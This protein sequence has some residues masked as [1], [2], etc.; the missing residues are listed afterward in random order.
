M[1]RPAA[2]SA[3]ALRPTSMLLGFAL[4]LLISGA[5]GP[6][7]ASDLVWTQEDWSGGQ[8]ESAVGIDPEIDPG[9]LV[10]ENHIDDF[11]V[12][13][14]PSEHQGLWSMEAY[15]D[16][17]FIT[18]GAYPYGL[19]GADVVVYDYLTNNFE[20]VYSPR[21]YGLHLVK[22]FDDVLYLPGPEA[23]D[24]T[25]QA[26]SIYS[27]DGEQWREHE[28]LTRAIHVNDV[29]VAHGRIYASTGQHSDFMEGHGCVWVSD[30][31]GETFSVA[32]SIAPTPDD[33]WRRFFGLGHIGDR[34]FA[35]PDGHAPETNMIFT[36]TDGVD[37][38]TT[39]INN[40]P[41]EKQAV[42][43]PWGEDSLLMGV[44]YRL[45]IWNGT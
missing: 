19:T 23:R 45:Y 2:S 25:F 32:Y 24:I 35:Q 15:H 33:M 37:W 4:A 17:L 36:T 16:T 28:E 3:H 39:T 8:Y 43:V 11:R 18:A 31:L 34:L 27:Y 22:E 41:I 40:M 9:R 13:G 44:D 5:C 6:A 14:T 21:E 26:G 1:R 42:F 7:I 10:L 38:D 29:E 30:D 20:I 12:V